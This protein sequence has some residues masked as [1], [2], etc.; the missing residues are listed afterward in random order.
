ML[1]YRNASENWWA[2]SVFNVACHKLCKCHNK[3]IKVMTLQNY[4]CTKFHASIW[5]S[6]TV[7]LKVALFSVSCRGMV[8]LNGYVT[9]QNNGYRSEENHHV[10]HGVTTG[11]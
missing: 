11:G 7:V 10:V 9:R 2:I 8:P 5:Y 6:K 3:S 1:D 4:S